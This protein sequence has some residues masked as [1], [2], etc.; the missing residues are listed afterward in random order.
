MEEEKNSSI[1]FVGKRFNLWTEIDAFIDDLAKK[2]YWIYSV[3]SSE[4][5]DNSF[6]FKDYYCVCFGAPRMT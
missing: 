1:S 4:A 6:K 3:R 5:F 2:Y